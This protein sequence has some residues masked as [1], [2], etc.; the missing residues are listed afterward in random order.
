[1]RTSWLSREAIVFGLWFGLAL[2]AETGRQLL[3]NVV[4]S[5]QLAVATFAWVVSTTA[6][7]GLFCSVMIYV[8]TRREFWR[9]ASTAPRLFG[10]AAIFASLALFITMP[11]WPHAAILGG[12]TL[13]KLAMETRVFRILDSDDETPTPARKT[14]LLLSGP[15]RV[16]TAF[17]Y[18][19]S[20]SGGLALPLCV[21]TGFLAVPSIWFGVA[22]VFASELAER[23]LFFRAVVAPK[24]PGVPTT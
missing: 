14:A 10:T 23:Y 21:A 7:L 8:D 13:L 9:L 18:V 11:D 5:H 2:S 20:I 1:L 12:I 4:A 16:A 6:V 19:S 17:R 24:M 22:L 15:L 3:P